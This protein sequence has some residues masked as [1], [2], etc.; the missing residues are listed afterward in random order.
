MNYFEIAGHLT[1]RLSAFLSHLGF[2]NIMNFSATVD[3]NTSEIYMKDGSTA[4]IKFLDPGTNC[5]VWS[6]DDFESRAIQLEDDNWEQVFDKE[7]FHDA[8]ESMIKNHDANIGIN[9]D[10][11]DYYLWNKC[12]K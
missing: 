1:G 12:K 11:I 7:L 5:V 6:V 10:T 8:L 9:W 4:R 2:R 3:Y